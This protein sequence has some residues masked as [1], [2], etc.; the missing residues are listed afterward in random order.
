M[1]S[2]RVKSRHEEA[3]A[4]N[5]RRKLTSRAQA[6]SSNYVIGPGD[7]PQRLSRMHRCAGRNNPVAVGCSGD[8][9]IAAIVV[10]AGGAHAV[11]TS[12]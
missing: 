6:K 9:G 10:V 1:M 8:C 7:Q 5:S 2:P 4:H 12:P 11:G 3:A